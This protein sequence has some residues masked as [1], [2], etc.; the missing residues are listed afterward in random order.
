MK[1]QNLFPNAGFD[2]EPSLIVA[3]AVTAVVM[4]G[5]FA[6]IALAILMTPPL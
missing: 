1:N 2:P 3:G 4:V 6:V 5:F